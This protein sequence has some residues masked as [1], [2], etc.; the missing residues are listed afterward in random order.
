MGHWSVVFIRLR[1][2]KL[3]LIY[4]YYS[5]IRLLEKQDIATC[6]EIFHKS[7][8]SNPFDIKQELEEQFKDTILAPEFYI[9]KEDNIIKWFWGLSNCRFDD[10]AYS[11]WRCY[12]LPEFQWRWIWQL[13]VQYRIDRIKELWGTVIF[14]TTQKKRHLERFWFKEIDSPYTKWHMMQFVIR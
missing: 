4:N 10:E 5:M 3:L 13:L 12:V 7:I 2:C 8:E 6:I 9:Y 14:S 11:I 1:D